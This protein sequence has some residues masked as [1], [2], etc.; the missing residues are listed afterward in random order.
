L[1]VGCLVV[2]GA[3]AA[4]HQDPHKRLT[5]A[6]NARAR[7]ML[8]KP[9]DLPGFQA[10]A[11]NRDDPHYDC[12][13]SVTEADLT[14]TGEARGKTFTT[15][16]V[17][18]ESGSQ[19]YESTADASASWRRSTSTA[20]IDCL[21]KLLRREYGKQGLQVV[22]VRKTAF[23]RLAQR[24]IVFRIEISAPSA[25]GPVP[26]FIDLVAQMHSRAQA[27]VIVGSG[28]VAPPRAEEL[29]L[30]RLVADRMAQAMRGA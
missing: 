20:G 8:V 12:A 14:L 23:P 1:L 13:A 4:N 18:V 7:A 5:K 10:Q 6:D 25:Q 17:F 21:T 28:V 11:S 9:S 2:V 30:A 26:V 16:V 3:A 27:T 19:I 15:G 24:T 22:S 29:R